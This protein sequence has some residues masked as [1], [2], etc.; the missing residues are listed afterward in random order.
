MNKAALVGGLEDRQSRTA[1]LGIHGSATCPDLS[2]PLQYYGSD[3]PSIRKLAQE[4]AELSEEIHER[5]PYTKAEVVWA[6]RSEM[7]RSVEDVLARRTR[8]LLLD[9]RAS[10]EAAPEVARLMA[11]ELGCSLQWQEGEVAAYDELAA[12]YHL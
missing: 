10:R 6:A 2:D 4:D 5:L 1:T 12:G 7:A 3:A 9:A 11:K 8:S